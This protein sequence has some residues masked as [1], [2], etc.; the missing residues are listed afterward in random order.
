VEK[1]FSRMGWA[2]DQF[3]Y[4]SPEA[5]HTAL[6]PLMHETQDFCWKG[7]ELFWGTKP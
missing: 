3:P 5:L 4:Y 6:D 1:I 2:I 7:I